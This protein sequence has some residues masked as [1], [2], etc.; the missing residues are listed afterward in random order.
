MW[1]LCWETQLA[2]FTIRLE[3]K[4]NRRSVA[5]R[6]TYGKQVKDYLDYAD[7]AKELGACMMHALACEGKVDNRKDGDDE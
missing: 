7:A 3:Q 2:G 1:E 4:R 5:F 6:V